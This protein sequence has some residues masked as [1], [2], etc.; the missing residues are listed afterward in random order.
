L[1]GT[2]QPVH[3]QHLSK[4]VDFHIISFPCAPMLVAALH[5]LD[6]NAFYFVHIG[7]SL[8]IAELLLITHHSSPA[9]LD[10]L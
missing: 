5:A 10:C 4:Q 2:L 9:A 1:F 3:D 8:A 7:V 6:G